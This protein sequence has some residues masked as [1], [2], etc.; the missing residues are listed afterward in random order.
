MTKHGNF[1]QLV[2]D[3]VVTIHFSSAFAY[4]GKIELSN[5]IINRFS[6]RSLVYFFFLRYDGLQIQTLKE[7]ILVLV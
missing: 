2:V 7:Y 6:A 4:L 5:P 3:V 1:P